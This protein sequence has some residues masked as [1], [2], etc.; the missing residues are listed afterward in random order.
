MS[1]TA[2]APTLRQDATVISL[3]GFAHGTSHFFHLMLPP[4]FPWF[5]SEYSLSYTQVGSLMTVFFVVSGIG[6]ALAGFLVDR[7]GAHRVLCLGVSL[8]TLS[9]LLLF[10]AP[11]LPGLYLAAFVAGLGNS[12]FHPADFALINH[13]VSPPRLGHAFSVHGLSGNLGWAAGPVL[14]LATATAFGWRAAGLVAAMVGASSLLLLWM[15]REVLSDHGARADGKPK[16]PYQGTLADLLKVPLIWFAFIFFF[17]ATLVFGALQNFAPTLFKELYGLSLTV[18]TSALTAYLLGSAAG[19]ATG[20]FLASAESGQER[21][22]T[23]AFVVGAVL[24]VVLALS[25]LPGWSI[26]GVMAVMG[27]C[28]GTAG[29]SRD[30]LV[31]KATAATLG[32]GAFGRVYGLVYSGLDTGLATAPLIFGAMLDAG[33][34]RAVFFGVAVAFAVAII[35]AQSVAWQARRATAAGAAE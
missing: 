14:M 4:L 18:A 12:V 10:A 7:W 13:R 25:W 17:S 8:L 6:Q 9:G 35:A 29:P 28:V 33:Q 24:A 32:T 16:V 15:N 19:I 2:P 22:V 34:P 3:V 26:I 31:R 23:A 11:G 5:I 27:F 21:L 1:A 20:G 30:M